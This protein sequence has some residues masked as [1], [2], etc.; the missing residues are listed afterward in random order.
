[1]NPYSG[2]FTDANGREVCEG[3]PVTCPRFPQTIFRLVEALSD[4]TAFIEWPDGRHMETKWT[5]LCYAATDTP[6]P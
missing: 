6:V 3:D 1:M 2:S 4:G 5:A